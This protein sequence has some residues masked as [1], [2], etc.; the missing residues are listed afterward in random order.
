MRQ[1][2]WAL[3]DYLRQVFLWLWLPDHLEVF[4]EHVRHKGYLFPAIEGKNIELTK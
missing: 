4:K 3:R 2:L 1:T